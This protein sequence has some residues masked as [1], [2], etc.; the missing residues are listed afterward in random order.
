MGASVIVV[1]RRI[2][3]RPE[4]L[5]APKGFVAMHSYTPESV[6]VPD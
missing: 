5:L 3:R 2:V 1:R 4:A 6:I